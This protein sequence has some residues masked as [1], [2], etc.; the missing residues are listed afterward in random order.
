MPQSGYFAELGLGLV[1]YDDGH[2]FHVIGKGET[3]IS[4][5]ASSDVGGTT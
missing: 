5:T 1:A 4:W 2:K 3:P